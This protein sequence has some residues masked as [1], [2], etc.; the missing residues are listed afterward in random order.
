MESEQ[1]KELP[2]F[3]KKEFEEFLKC[4]LPAYGFLRLQCESCRQERLLAFSCKRRGFCPSCG[5]KRMAE[6]AAHLVD[7]VFPHKPL[8]QWVLSFP[9]PLRILFA[10]DPQ[11]M[12]LVLNPVNRAISTYLIKKAGLKKK[13]GAKTGSVTF[14]QRFG[15]SLNL[16]I[17]FYI[18]YLDGVYSFE[19]EKARFHFLTPPS[20]SELDNLLKTLAQRT[21]KLLKKRGLIVRTEGTEN[22][23]LNLKDPEAIDHI[24]SSSITYR[25]AFGKYKGQ[26][27]LT[28]GVIP[29]FKAQKEKKKP[30]LSKYSSFSL[31]AG[32][33]CSAPNRKKRERLCR[34][35]SRPSLSEQRLS[36]NVQ[37]QVVYKLK[38]A[39]RKGTTHIILDPL[40]FLS[41]PTSLIPRPRIH[42]TRFHGVFAPHCKYRSLITPQSALSEKTNKTSRTE[43]KKAYS[44]TWAKMLKRVFDIDIQTCLKCGGQ[45]QNHLCYSK[46]TGY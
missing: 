30:F 42:L 23:F 12:G 8:R 33:S 11:L 4:G 9:F 38:T 3:V 37:G 26:K 20:Q 25:I 1:E 19:R 34:Y 29:N 17:H 27:A 6:S 10:K 36:I 24:H 15:G 43:R 21:V 2:H 35:I 22:Q 5:A 41:R 39:Y 18:M 16:N 7:E 28:L 40:D 14:I 44:R 13:S 46:S 32:I 31:H 45:S